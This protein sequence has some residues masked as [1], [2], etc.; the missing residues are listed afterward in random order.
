MKRMRVKNRIRIFVIA[1]LVMVFGMTLAGSVFLIS[2]ASADETVRTV[3]T[4]KLEEMYEVGSTI[5][6]PDRYLTVDGERVPAQKVVHCPDGTD[7]SGAEITPAEIGLY[8]V[9]YFAYDSAGKR[10]S[11]T[12]TFMVSKNLYETTGAGTSAVYKAHPLTPNHKGV[13]V[14]LRNGELFRYNGLIDF[15]GKTAKDRFLSLYLTPVAPGD[16]D[17]R[18]LRIELIDHLNPTNKVIIQVK[19]SPEGRRH[20]VTFISAGATGQNSIGREDNTGKLHVDNQWG[21]PTDLTFYGSDA[22]GKWNE[23]FLVNNSLEL[24]F[25]YEGE[26]KEL[27][28]RR[29][30]V[31]PPTNP[32]VIIGLADPDYY[33]DNLWKGFT[34]GKA[35]LTIAIEDYKQSEGSFVITDIAGQ[36]LTVN[37]MID[38]E[39]PVIEVDYDGYESIPNALIDHPYPIFN[40]TA[41]AQYTKADVTVE[42]YENYN[43]DLRSNCEITNGTFTPRSTG[44]Y[45]IVYT[46]KDYSGNVSRELVTVTC[47]ASVEEVELTV[48]EGAAVKQG[49]V[50]EYLSLPYAAARKGVGRTELSVTVTDPE[51]NQVEILNGGFRPTLAG[52]YR[53]RYSAKDFVSQTK[54]YEYS[55]TVSDSE[56]AV[57]DRIVMPK[58]LV[59]G[60]P[61]T[62]PR[63]VAYLSGNETPV[64]ITLS[65]G[66]GTR[67]LA[68]DR[69][70]TIL[71]DA[72]GMANIVYSVPGSDAEKAFTVPVI[73]VG[74]TEH[75][76]IADYFILDG[77][78]AKAGYNS[79]AFTAER[80]AA[81]TFIQ[82][83]LSEN[84]SMKFSAKLQAG[85][86][87][88]VTL[89]DS[90]ND[91]NSV[92][93]EFAATD[94][95]IAF[96]V[97]GGSPVALGATDG[98]F[99]FGYSESG[100]SITVGRKS[101]PV[102]KNEAGMQFDGFASRKVYLGV[103]LLGVSGKQTVEI[104]EINRQPVTN[105]KS[106]RTAPE[107]TVLGE[108]ADTAEFGEE[109]T[110]FAAVGGDVLDMGAH[111][112]VSVTGPKG[113]L[114]YSD[115][116]LLLNV[117]ADRE[118]KLK[119]EAYGT[120]K[121]VYSVSDASG[122]TFNRIIGIFIPD[123]V[124]PEMELLFEL[125]DTYHLNDVIVFASVKV[126]DNFSDADSI[127]LYRFIITP[128]GRIFR[129]G[130]NSFVANQ[131]GRYTLIY[132]AMDE[133]GNICML[134]RSITVI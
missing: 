133:A 52:T 98:D 48:D 76:S 29:L 87:L 14:V 60:F 44:R 130:G 105:V 51:G 16:N 49:S 46:A 24:F 123:E 4:G 61:I 15:N 13:N 37:S 124:S 92:I 9:E 109:L 119:I 33:G 99:I 22:N 70:A 114:I 127:V 112:T 104:S 8:T 132:Q 93:A 40:A 120:Y 41:H 110:V 85:N 56:N 1:L 95:G 69:K 100:R 47:V 12:T 107:L 45:T 84:F 77:F 64:E 106:D 23:A 122:K 117:E 5:A 39:P 53:V 32:D 103:E 108:Y 128:T 28:G 35:Y 17:Y 63:G 97:S 26:L 57:F 55:V 101:V 78:T 25:D 88:R 34:D 118:F 83:L 65:D 10:V 74:D 7:V 134:E 111:A 89:T 102:H 11:E 20:P 73:P 18:R 125:E 126:T 2:R 79:V 72:D 42:V 115:G 80:D 62:L 129:L 66:L 3:N 50:G 131:T 71:A 59:E 67:K 38:R 6:I 113:R 36:D 31:L 30:A 94:G 75:L 121:I 86:V 54:E 21:F 82:S 116:K 90:A 43:S 19:R 91:K 58:Y 96:T 68:S 27:H 81:L